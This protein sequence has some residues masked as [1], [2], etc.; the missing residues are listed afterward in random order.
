MEVGCDWD[1]ESS[2]ERFAHF[3]ESAD[4]IYDDPEVVPLSQLMFLF[5]RH[6]EQLAAR[7]PRLLL[8]KLPPVT[9]RIPDL[10]ITVRMSLSDRSLVVVQG[11]V[12]DVEIR[13]QPLAFLYQFPFGSQTLG[14]SA[15]LRVFGHRRIWRLYRILYALNNAEL[16]L[17]P[18]Y[19]LKGE[20]LSFARDRLRGGARQLG[21]RLQRG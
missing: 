5:G 2:L 14:V 18:R 11:G 6:A 16:Y 7:Y 1:N 17:K 20:N 9:I 21:Q 8:Q 12:A 10:D 13:S 3:Y 4:W 15:R 19:L